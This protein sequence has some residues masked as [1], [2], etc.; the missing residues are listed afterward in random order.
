MPASTAAVA[1]AAGFLVIAAF[2]LALAF[3]APF[4]HAA[5]GGAHERLPGRLRIASAVAVGIWL[6]ASIVV[7]QRGGLSLVPLPSAVAHWASWILVGLLL[8]GAI[9]NFASS[10][11]WERF[12]W[13]PLG[14]IL[15]VLCLIV[16]T[17]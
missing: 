10:S 7:V 4:G 1:A 2:Q 12:G 5:W 8:L 3:G 14:L 15:A 9:M 11:P 16:A 6:V 13:G 17:G